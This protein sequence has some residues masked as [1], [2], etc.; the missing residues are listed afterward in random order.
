MFKEL[1]DLGNLF[2]QAAQLQKNM[3][4]VQE[5]L[6]QVTVEGQAGGGMVRVRANGKQEV[7]SCAIEPSVLADQDAATLEVLIVSATNQ[8]LTKA[9]D[10]ATAAMAEGFGPEVQERIR[11][12]L[13]GMM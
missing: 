2:K 1:G 8:A 6:G 13:G 9:R 11:K 7:L 4:G 10:A 3:A 12:G 5:K